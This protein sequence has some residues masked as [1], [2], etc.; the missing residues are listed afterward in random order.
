MLIRQKNEFFDDPL[1]LHYV[2]TVSDDHFVDDRFAE[3]HRLKIV[4]NEVVI[5]TC[6]S[7]FE[8]GHPL[9]GNHTKC[10]KILFF[11]KTDVSL[12]SF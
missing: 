9:R 10:V 5:A 6:S 1:G 2:M 11:P 4:I 8:E 7:S 12:R 3:R